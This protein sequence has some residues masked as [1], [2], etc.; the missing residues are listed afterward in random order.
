M[1]LGVAQGPEI[2]ATL[3]Q[4]LDAVIDGEVANLAPDLEEYAL[5]NVIGKVFQKV[6]KKC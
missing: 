4:L 3:T 2:G 1:R 5:R 6:A